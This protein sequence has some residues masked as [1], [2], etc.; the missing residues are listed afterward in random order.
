MHNLREPEAAW[1]GYNKGEVIDRF[2][3]PPIK[4]PEDYEAH[5]IAR[6][7]MLSKHNCPTFQMSAEKTDETANLRQ[8]QYRQNAAA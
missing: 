3:T 1:T 5:T 4:S 2:P 8:Q 6:L 7:S